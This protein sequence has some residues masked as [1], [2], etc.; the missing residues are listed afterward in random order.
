MQQIPIKQ[1]NLKIYL[2]TAL[3]I[4]II[5]WAWWAIENYTDFR[6]RPRR[7]SGN[8]E[9]IDYI[10][11]LIATPLTLIGAMIWWKRD[12]GM[13]A[14]GVVVTATIAK[15]GRSVNSMRNITLNY[16][17]DGISYNV[18]KSFSSV[19]F[20]GKQ[21][22]DSIELISDKRKPKKILLNQ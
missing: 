22:G 10:Y 21:E 9:A 15:I 5:L 6:I 17:L 7:S 20:D 1:V 14:N 13:V 18:K 8:S 2:Y 4:I 12:A 16:S 3:F 19:D 11:P